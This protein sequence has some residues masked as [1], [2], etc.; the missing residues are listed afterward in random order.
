MLFA[1][2]NYE[3][4]DKKLLI[5]IRAF[6]FWRP[7]LERTEQFVIILLDYKSFEYFITIK[8]FNHRQIRW[9]EF[10]F[11]FNFKIIYRFEG[12]NHRVNVFIR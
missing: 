1:E 10:L 12:F 6:E 4:Y 11:K 8:L 2:C 7:E 9:S 3:V 5:I